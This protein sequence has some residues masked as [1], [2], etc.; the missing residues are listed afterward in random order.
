MIWVEQCIDLS[1]WGWTSIIGFTVL[2]NSQFVLQHNQNLTSFIISR[3]VSRLQMT[4]WGEIYQG[5]NKKQWEILSACLPKNLSQPD[6]FH[7]AS[8]YYTDE[9]AIDMTRFSLE[10]SMGWYPKSWPS[11]FELIYCLWGFSTT[12]ITN[13]TVKTRSY[14]LFCVF[15]KVR[16]R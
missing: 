12:L 9:R 7:Y 10:S 5:K 13:M 15:R 2:K 11:N 14:H 6:L 4:D 1:F 8:A 3:L 16:I